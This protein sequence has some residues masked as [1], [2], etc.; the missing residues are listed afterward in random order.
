VIGAVLYEE[1]DDGLVS[2]FGGDVE[3]GPAARTDG[4]D[5]CASLEQRTKDL[6]VAAFGCVVKGR[7]SGD[8]A[9]GV[10]VCAYGEKVRDDLCVAVGRGFVERRSTVSRFR[11]H[12]DA[13]DLYE[14]EEGV[15]ISLRR[16][17]VDGLHAFGVT[18]D[19][20]GGGTMFEYGDVAG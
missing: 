1:F 7:P 20:I 11:I 4:V 12:G 15:F 19:E 17:E 6:L 3:G 8:S 2:S 14:I 13:R 18:D 16:G 5:V 10:W 9:S